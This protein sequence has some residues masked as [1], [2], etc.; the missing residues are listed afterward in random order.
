MALLFLS[1]KTFKRI[2]QLNIPNPLN[3]YK[4][5]YVVFSLYR[6]ATKNDKRGTATVFVDFK[7]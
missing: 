6:E 5:T 3:L 1:N 7:N 2:D 4:C